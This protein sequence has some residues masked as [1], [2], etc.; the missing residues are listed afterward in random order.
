L[1]R[2]YLSESE[3]II[4]AINVESKHLSLL[5][6]D[7]KAINSTL[8]GENLFGYLA[9]NGFKDLFSILLRLAVH[10]DQLNPSDTLTLDMFLLEVDIQ[11]AFKTAIINDQPDLLHCLNDFDW[12]A[13]MKIELLKC[14]ITHKKSAAT[15]ILMNLFSEIIN[16]ET[17]TE[18][19]HIA[20][21]N[22]DDD[23]MAALLQPGIVFKLRNTNLLLLLAKSGKD[24]SL[25]IDRL[26]IN[27]DCNTVDESGYTALHYA[28]QESNINAVR[29]LVRLTNLN[30]R[31]NNG[32]TPYELANKLHGIAADNDKRQFEIMKLLAEHGADTHSQNA[33]VSNQL[34]SQFPEWIALKGGGMKG[35]AYLSAFEE[36]Q[37]RYLINLQTTTGFIGTSAGAITALLLALRIPLPILREKMEKM[38]FTTFL[39]Y[40]DPSI[41]EYIMKKV[42]A[43][44][45]LWKVLLKKNFFLLKA[46]SI[47]DEKLGACKG[48]A[49]LEWLYS[50]IKEATIGTEL[51]SISPETIT[52][53]D[54][55]KYPNRFA[56]LVVY[57][58][59]MT[60]GRSERYCFETT[61]DMP[62]ADAVRI[63]MSLPIIFQPHRK[64]IVKDGKRILDPYD[65]SLCVDGGLLCNYP[66]KDLDLDTTSGRYKRNAKVLGFCLVS[67][68]EHKEFEL[69]HRPKATDHSENGIISFVLNM[70]E[71]GM[72]NV[73]DQ[74]NINGL[75]RDR[76]IYINTG[77]IGT[78][79][80]HLSRE[81]L[82][83][84]NQGG[85]EG[86][87][88]FVKR[89]QTLPPNAI[90]DYLQ[91]RLF[92][93]GLI[94]QE[95]VTRAGDFKELT[96]A[97]IFKLYAKA[98]DDE[99]DI[100]RTI[101][102]PNLSDA[103][104]MRAIHI[105]QEFGFNEAQSRLI[106]WNANE[107]V[108]Y[109]PR[110]EIRAAIKQNDII[111]TAT[112]TTIKLPKAARVIIE[113]DNEIQKLKAQL[114]ALSAHH[115]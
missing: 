25:H 66:V 36:A 91:K 115:N 111:H 35:L 85:R 24:Y 2:D 38:D 95:G 12:Y 105:A 15:H 86:V 97:R 98:N 88:N 65:E 70:V 43:G 16:E 96:A 57:G 114:E 107:K 1:K 79:E 31:E 56:E 4:A 6:A 93:L 103:N 33:V 73:Q 30:I 47:L 53:R 63:S 87:R 54:L 74:D 41:F 55:K 76:T 45:D 10:L 89:K 78:T 83:I 58:A 42:Q 3:R 108:K 26:L 48:E 109:I 8:A 52:F 40:H 112:P 101:V 64:Y 11:Q 72:F 27:F 80:F 44:K 102:N 92:A 19:F 21:E 32:S 17:Y 5:L 110:E 113:K 84:L 22:Y 28:I 82:E 23:V 51:E 81:R 69:R 29:K 14:A 77:D 61:P 34:P 37:K 94:T 18:L 50:E 99:L 62:I 7:I 100:L 75:D 49:F 9:K 59:N 39:D 106:R 46:K 13:N 67:D 71:A 60:T 20:I 90:S 68:A 104:G